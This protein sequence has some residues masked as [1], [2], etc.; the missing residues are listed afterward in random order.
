L[1]LQRFRHRQGF[2]IGSHQ[3]SFRRTMCITSE[4]IAPSDIYPLRMCRMNPPEKFPGLS[5]VRA[6]ERCVGLSVCRAWNSAASLGAGPVGMPD[7]RRR[8][9]VRDLE[10]RAAAYEMT[11]LEKVDR[12]IFEHSDRARKAG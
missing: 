6:R 7:H 11:Y 4:V 10:F 9:D 5:G 8:A 1:R 12:E 3:Q 2:V